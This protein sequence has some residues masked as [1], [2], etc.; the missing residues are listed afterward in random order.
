MYLLCEKLILFEE[1]IQTN[2]N[3][4]YLNLNIENNKQNHKNNESQNLVRS[5]R[6]S[7]RDSSS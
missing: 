7:R 1:E 3:F 2:L 4:V 6:C 5:E